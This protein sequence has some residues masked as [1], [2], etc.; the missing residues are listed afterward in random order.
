MEQNRFD[1]IKIIITNN[2]HNFYINAN[3]NKTDD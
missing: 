3:V 2:T 1:E